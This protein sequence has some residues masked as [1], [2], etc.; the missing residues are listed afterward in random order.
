M[1]PSELLR[2]KLS[3]TPQVTASR[4][5]SPTPSLIRNN[6]AQK[7]A[8]LNFNK[9]FIPLDNVKVYPCY[10][11]TSYVQ[12]YGAVN[13]WWDVHVLFPFLSM[14]TGS[15]I[16]SSPFLM[17]IC[18]VILGQDVSLGLTIPYC[19]DRW[20]KKQ[21]LSVEINATLETIP[22]GDFELP[23]VFQFTKQITSWSPL[24]LKACHTFTHIAEWINIVLI[25][26]C[27]LQWKY[28]FVKSVQC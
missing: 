15:K 12:H 8:E 4:V 7:N 13:Y 23:L 25:W 14:K 26:R 20:A 17:Y 11:H 28:S 21:A 27:L 2:V 18:M 24:N 22:K 5:N 6:S 9:I 10:R 16:H 19:N 3:Q 1:T